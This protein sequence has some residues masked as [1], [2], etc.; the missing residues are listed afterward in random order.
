MY[1]KEV[2]CHYKK[3]P[4]GYQV[5]CIDTYVYPVTNYVLEKTEWIDEL[6][7]VT[8]SVHDTEELAMIGVND[9]SL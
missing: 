7:S 1:V 9:E 5:T 6:H 4:F 8:Y 3:V 2:H